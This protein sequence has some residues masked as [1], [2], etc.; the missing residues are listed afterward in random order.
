ME[1]LKNRLQK[2]KEKI[3]VSANK[4]NRDPRNI[5][6]LPISKNQSPEK[7]NYFYEQG[8]ETFG[9]NRVQELREKNEKLKNKNINWHFVGHL[10]RNKVKYLLRMNNCIMIQSVDSLRLARE[11]NKRASKN[12]REISILIE[13]NVSGDQSKFGFKPEKTM[14]SIK[15]IDQLSW[16]NQKGLMTLAPYVEDPEESR[17]YFKKLAEIFQEA[18][19]QGYQL[20]ELSMGMTNDYQI[21][22]EEGATIVRVGR[23]LF[24]SRR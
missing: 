7:I 3:T 19:E 15:K 2:V 1:E 22:I 18:N 12:N 4:V 13:V 5:K 16:L 8:I 17:P 14:K 6:L 9:E 24:G 23:G 11:I 21:A 10:Q 20:S